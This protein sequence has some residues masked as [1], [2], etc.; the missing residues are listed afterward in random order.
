MKTG[1]LYFAILL[2]FISCEN[3]ENPEKLII[4]KWELVEIYN[5]WTGQSSDLNVNE[6]FQTYQFMSNGSF[7][8]TRLFEDEGL[9]TASGNYSLE[10]V[11]PT[12]SSDAQLYINL[13]FIDGDDILNNCG[14]ENF[15]Q[16]VLRFNHQ[17]SNFSATSCDGP[18]YTFEKK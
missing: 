10:N 12:S 9:K 15:E 3:E 8:K 11:P 16:L 14:A 5:P 17:L 2:L 18:G 1:F 7:T 6:F 4:G 13:N